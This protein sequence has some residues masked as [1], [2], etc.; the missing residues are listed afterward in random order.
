MAIILRLV[1][2]TVKCGIAL[3]IQLSINFSVLKLEFLQRIAIWFFIKNKKV[4]N[5]IDI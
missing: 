1:F 2:K 5:K 4:L 3:A